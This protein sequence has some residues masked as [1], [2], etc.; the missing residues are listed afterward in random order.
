[1]INETMFPPLL[2]IWNPFPEIRPSVG[3]FLTSAGLEGFSDLAG[4]SGLTGVTC[5]FWSWLAAAVLSLLP[6][7]LLPQAANVN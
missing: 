3:L 5:V 1:M 6:P 2:G 7:P 4:T